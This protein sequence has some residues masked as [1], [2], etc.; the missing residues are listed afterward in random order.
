MITKLDM[1][2]NIVH[3][4]GFREHKEVWYLRFNDHLHVAG[5]IVGIGI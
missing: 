5:D 1:I 2:S 3:I 4:Y